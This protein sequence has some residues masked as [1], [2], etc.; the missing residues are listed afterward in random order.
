MVREN[1][2][3][4]RIWS[5]SY[6]KTGILTIFRWRWADAGR[7]WRE[8]GGEEKKMIYWQVIV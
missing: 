7:D 5:R 3:Q 8:N 2:E 4:S 6:I 1:A